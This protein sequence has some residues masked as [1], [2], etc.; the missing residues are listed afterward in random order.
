MPHAAPP[1]ASRY[2][3]TLLSDAGA[4]LARGDVA[5]V[6]VLCG[7]VR[8]QLATAVTPARVA[9][10][11]AR[12]EARAS[13]VEGNP[14]A[15]LDSLTT[16]LAIA[17]A[18]YDATGAAHA[19]NHIAIVQFA[20]GRLDEAQ[21]HFEAARTR[22]RVLGE[23][24]LVAA[25]TANLGAIANI[26]GNVR[27]AISALRRAIKD[28]RVYGQEG[29][30]AAP[31]NNLGMALADLGQWTGAE[32]AYR[33]ALDIA[34]RA[35]DSD[36]QIRLHGNLA[37]TWI[38]RGDLARAHQACS[39][40]MALAVTNRHANAVGEV[41]KLFGI[42]ARESGALDVAEGE[43]GRAE[44]AARARE[45]LLLLAETAREQADL[46]RRQSRNRDTLQALNR[47]HRLFEQLRARRDLADVDRRMSRLEG[48]FV[49]VARRWGESIEAA[50]R[51]TQGHCQRVAD[52]AC[53]IAERA[54]FDAQTMF[55]F[56]IGAL[57]HDVGKLVIP[58]EVLNKPGKL[59]D[60]EFALMRSHT[61][62]GVRMLADVEFPWDVR[63]I[64]ESHHERW[65]GRG[66]PHGLA[67][68]AIPLTARILCIADVYDALTSVRSYKRALSHGDA[69]GLLRRDCGTAFDPRVFAWFEAV[70]PAW[71]ARIGSGSTREHE[72]V[73][74]DTRARRL[75]S[76]LDVLTGL[77]TR[78]EFFR[79][80]ERVLAARANDGRPTGLVILR[81]VNVDAAVA[82]RGRDAVDA[83][84]AAIGEGLSRNTRGG[85][86][87]GRYSDA[88]FVVLLPDEDLLHTHAAATRLRECAEVTCVLAPDGD[89]AAVGRAPLRVNVGA[90]A[91]PTHGRTGHALLAAAD[92]ALRRCAGARFAA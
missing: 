77:P 61:T 65:D 53:L 46:Y 91:A 78:A 56:R 10:A 11:V 67:G 86:F 48:D 14:D 68:E 16:A 26:R 2:V 38:G 51:Y 33:E 74:A 76:G 8:D 20:R 32:R 60:E 49:G 29:D 36:G 54:G 59:T 9:G 41:H 89:G 34:T 28:L 5:E 66:Y 63:P 70:A 27:G 84:L 82:D 88:E 81:A 75:A 73:G 87:V 62:E 21:T 43:F 19:L 58:G 18:S 17:E 1:T 22:G 25:A 39:D 45:D 15:A 30:L 44:Q 12:L 83:A 40:A 79:E 50:D 80:C 64:L 57:L 92:A 35:G 90:A 31:L 13:L 72:T 55:W 85:D 7:A 52:L 4:A 23:R 24:T 47:A 37:E 3:D 6:R 42:I 69:M 71:G